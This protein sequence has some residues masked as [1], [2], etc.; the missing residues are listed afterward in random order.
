MLK[1]LSLVAITSTILSCSVGPGWV[2]PTLE[3]Q[4]NYAGAVLKGAVTQVT[5][6]QFTGFLVTVSKANYFKGCGPSVVRISGYR[7]SSLCTPDPPKVGDS[8]FAF[9]CKGTTYDW[10]LNRFEVGTGSLV[11]TND[12]EQKVTTLTADEYRCSNCCFMFKSCKKR[13]V[14][15]IILPVAVPAVGA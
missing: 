8:I 4:V 14:K 5:G 12:I 1:L 7:G 6:N 2:A 11:A 10:D 15:P 13:P 3:E 9:V